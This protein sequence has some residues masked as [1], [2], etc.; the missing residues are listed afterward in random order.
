MDKIEALQRITLTMEN[1]KEIRAFDGKA[2]LLK[3][4]NNIYDLVNLYKENWNI[5]ELCVKE[6]ESLIGYVKE[7]SKDGK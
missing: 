5:I 7:E 1:I 3:K 2:E 6:A 4:L